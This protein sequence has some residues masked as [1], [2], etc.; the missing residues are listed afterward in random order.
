M[1]YAGTLVAAGKGRGLVV[2]TGMKTEI[3][4]IAGLV[5]QAREPRTPLQQA[6]G[7]LSRWLLWVAIGF[8]VLVPVLGALVAGQPVREMLL[9]GLTLAFATI[10]EE[11]PILITIVLGLGAYRLAQRNA[12]VKRL[13]AAET[14]GSVSVVA[15]DKTG[16]L[17]ENR[18]R[19]AKVLANGQE[20]TPDSAAATAEGRPLLLVAT[21]ANDG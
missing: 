5:K 11:L 18:M 15:T 14:L 4:R 19:L 17:T 8:S 3:G 7:E 6:L 12:I 10:P 13:Q 2:A 20:L 1:A 21:L 16:T 9:T